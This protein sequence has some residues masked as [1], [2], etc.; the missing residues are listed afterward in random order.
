MFAA[1]PIVFQENRGWSE[2]IGGLAFIGI[3]VG[4]VTAVIYTI[5]DNKRYNKAAADNE[6]RAPPEARLPPGIIGCF[7]LPVGLFWFAVSIHSVVLSGSK[8]L[9]V[10]VDKFTINSLVSL[11]H[12]HSSLR[13][14]HGL[15][16][17][18]S[19]E[20]SN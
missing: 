4:M 17:F 13:I 10:T 5:P 11:R 19:D 9:I 14:R 8:E 1:F 2:G 20:L 15:G 12:Q 6:G 7:F 3:A 16:V 18:E